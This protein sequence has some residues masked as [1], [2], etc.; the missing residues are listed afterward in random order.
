MK[1][2]LPDA[3]IRWFVFYFLI[4]TANL[5]FAGYGI[6]IDNNNQKQIKAAD[7]D[8]LISVE[9]VYD[10]SKKNKL[11]LMVDVTFKGDESGKT[12]IFITD[13][14][15]DQTIENCIRNLHVVSSNCYIEENGV[16]NQ[17]LITH[18]PRATVTIRYYLFDVR[19]FSEIE[20][21]SRFQPI[22]NEKYF[23]VFGEAF[24]ILPMSNWDKEYNIK[25]T[26]KNLPK[27]WSL[28]NSFGTFKSDQTIRMNLW[29]FR[30]SVFM[31]GNNVR[32]ITKYVSGYPF[33]VA[34]IG[35][36]KFS[37]S[38]LSDFI[39]S[40][41][42]ETRSF[43]KDTKYY[44]YLITVLSVNSNHAYL[45]EGREN[46]F[47]LFVGPMKEFD[48]NFQKMIS[49]EVFQNWLGRIIQPEEPKQIVSWFFS[50]FNEYYAR[51]LLLRAG[52]ISLEDYVNEYNAILEEYAKSPMRSES[53]TQI[54][55]EYLSNTDFNLVQFYKGD[56]IA[57]N[58]NSAIFNYTGGKKNLDDFMLDLYSRSRKENMPISNGVLSAL[59]R[60]YA[61]EKTL[62]EIMS[63][64]NSGKP[65]KPRPEALGRCSVLKV[66]YARAFWVLG[67][68]YEI[69]SY[70]FNKKLYYQ[71]RDEF[72]KWFN[73]S[74]E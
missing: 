56:I 25:L 51:L 72:L 35:N 59:I 2:R 47:S 36:F 54:N 17:K 12:P 38:Y 66:E 27:N 48:Y 31:G 19:I 63:S 53:S 64:I 5:S 71:N 13:K 67:E 18:A 33:Y 34:M 22:I 9:P 32:I 40:Q 43:W 20:I 70:V 29:K 39:W 65:L 61:G 8:L 21:A 3:F 49:R 50:G 55:P 52:K 57:H 7:N 26:W 11:S 46:S 23:H 73:Q 24:F 45:S 30:Q 42:Q 68:Q 74:G 41:M 28:A 58:L 62:S 4:L 10:Y 44:N 37:D 16:Q 14:F 6:S 60:F 69:Y 1:K 15:G